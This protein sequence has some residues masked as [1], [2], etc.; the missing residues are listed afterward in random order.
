MPT[1]EEINTSIRDAI[2]TLQTALA[3]AE[4]N[5]MTIKI[6][7]KESEQFKYRITTSSEIEIEEISA[8]TEY[9]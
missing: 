3:N 1:N 2:S 6:N 7:C 9:N 5:G 4:S 8:K